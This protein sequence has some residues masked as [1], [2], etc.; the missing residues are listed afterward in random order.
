MIL[1]LYLPKGLIFWTDWGSNPHIGRC[2]MDGSNAIIVYLEP[3]SWPNS[4]ALDLES[5]SVFFVDARTDQ[6]RSMDYDGKNQ[7]LVGTG[8]KLMKHPYALDWDPTLNALLWNDWRADGL[9]FAKLN[10]E[11][12]NFAQL[13]TIVYSVKTKSLFAISVVSHHKQPKSSRGNCADLIHC[14]PEQFCVFLPAATP[15]AGDRSGSVPTCLK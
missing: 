12:S 5:R 11:K 6:V 1:I 15:D 9:V 3:R 14:Q 13:P 10:A 8:G 2:N 7:R 4:L